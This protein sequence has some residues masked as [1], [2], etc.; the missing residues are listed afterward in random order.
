[1]FG[2]YNPVFL[3]IQSTNSDYEYIID[4]TRAAKPEELPGIIAKEIKKVA[5]PSF[6]M[7]I[8]D[9]ADKASSDAERDALGQLAT[10]ATEILQ[11]LLKV[12]EG[13]MDQA[14]KVVEAIVVSAAEPDGQFLVPLSAER[15]AAMKMVL[16]RFAE[17]LDDN[18]L[19]TVSTWMKKA[20]EDKMDGMVGILQRVL[21]LYA[22][23]ALKLGAPRREGEAPA[24]SQLFDD[25]L[26]SD[27]E[28]WRG[29]VRK[30]L[31]EERRCSADDLMGAIQVAI[32]S[33]VMQ[34]ENGSMSQRVQAEFLG[35][36]I[37]LVKEIQVQEKK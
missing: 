2:E 28:L 29:L 26:D 27:P 11:E 37:E 24:S 1:L 7:A 33:V 10:E 5:S 22:A 30:G 31:V 14:G 15:K 6:F 21:Q 9:R 8:A 20:E 35:E 18:F 25:L 12:A 16:E 32:E 23:N 17:E 19:S 3:L 4:A 36:L 34:Q 13:Q